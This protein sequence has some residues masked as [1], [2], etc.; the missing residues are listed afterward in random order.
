MGQAEIGV[1]AMAGA[2]ALPDEGA[3]GPGG[4]GDAHA[5]D[6]GDAPAGPLAFADDALGLADAVA[7]EGLA[8]PAI[9]AKDA[10][11]LLEHHKAFEV[12]DAAL[13]LLTGGDVGAVE[14]SGKGLDLLGRE[15][16]SRGLLA[17]I[18]GIGLAEHLDHRGPRAGSW[19]L[20]LLDG[21]VAVAGGGG[22]VA[23]GGKHLSS[24]GRK[25]VSEL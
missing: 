9:K 6:V 23:V 4:N 13:A 17:A 12:T 24:D 10:I 5:G 19:R 16:Q 25:R 18:C 20:A 7:G 22:V 8:L 21:P 15:A 2:S 11:G 1:D 3:M 14:G